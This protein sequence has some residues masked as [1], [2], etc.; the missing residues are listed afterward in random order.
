MMR[1]NL[2]RLRWMLFG[3]TVALSLSLVLGTTSSGATTNDA[4][5]VAKARQALAGVV[6]TP[7]SIGITTPLGK[8]PVGK[9]VDYVECGLSDCQIIGTQLQQAMK[10][11]GVKL[12]IVPAGSTAES[13]GAAF[14]QVVQNHPDGVMVG[15]IGKSLWSRQ[16]ATLTKRKTPVVS[17][18]TADPIGGAIKQ[19]LA[20]PAFSRIAGGRGADWIINNSNGKANILYIDVPVLSFT[21]PFKAGFEATL[22]NNCPTCT[23]NFIS[24][25]PTDIGTNV[26]TEVVSYLQAHPD[27]TYLYVPFGAVYTG[28]Y[29]ALRAAGL[30]GKVTLFGNEGVQANFAAVQSGDEKADLGFSDS[31]LAWVAA[32]S[33]ARELNGQNAA[34]VDV[35][36]KL[37]WNQLITSKNITWNVNKFPTWPYFVGFQKQFVKL[38]TEKK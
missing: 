38:W 11:L 22:H 4:A 17:W 37:P 21:A 16:F 10:V 31:Y 20:G 30:Q 3:L 13:F 19:T 7:T 29:A 6:R 23:V 27:T 33:M 32:D 18:G 28:V 14:T 15:G 35:D 1:I 25:S 5:G 8:R 2:P 26:P 12:K 9:T 34:K 24:V 36:T